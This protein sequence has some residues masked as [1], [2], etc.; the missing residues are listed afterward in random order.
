MS[1]TVKE[2]E[3]WKEERKRPSFEMLLQF[4]FIGQL[5]G[6]L[7][8]F[9]I[10]AFRACELEQESLTKTLR[11]DKSDDLE[12]FLLTLF[13]SES[14]EREVS[15]ALHLKTAWHA[16]ISRCRTAG[17][18]IVQTHRFSLNYYRE[19]LKAKCK[20]VKWGEESHQKL[21]DNIFFESKWGRL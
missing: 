5:F 17:V 7:Q 6:F 11:K 3:H 2:S 8:A 19:S 10:L 15:A 21:E 18:K 1:F 20:G 9:L 16:S 13:S 4:P 14:F 12:Y